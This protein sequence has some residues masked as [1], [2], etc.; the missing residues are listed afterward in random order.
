[1]LFIKW[2][3]ARFNYE[4]YFYFFV[5][6]DILSKNKNNILFSNQKIAWEKDIKRFF[7]YTKHE[8]TFREIT[9]EIIEN[10][11]IVIPFTISEVKFLAKN[12]NLLKNSPIPVS[13]IKTIEI[14]DD[15]YLFN[16]T[17]TEN[18]FGNYIPRM[19]CER[20]FPYFLKKRTGSWGDST[21]LIS[22]Q[23]DEDLK[24]N[25]IQDPEYFCQEAIFGKNEYATHI[26]IKERKIKFSLTIKHHFKNDLL[27]LGKTESHFQSVVKC[28]HLNLFESILNSIDYDGLCCID[29]K[30]KDNTPKIT[31]INPRFGG[32]LSRHFMYLFQYLNLPEKAT[33][34]NK[35]Y[36][37]INTY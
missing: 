8:I 5:I 19:D 25:L 21:Y 33:T 17:L 29:Y 9:P 3:F 12:K 10:Y 30:I 13:D 1:M 36:N 28:Q 37:T 2:I 34:L 35:M 18:G 31:E 24:I 11:D 22:N 14:C 4:F 15:K 7:N 23:L 20:T 16:K 32:T 27:I 26:L 6:K